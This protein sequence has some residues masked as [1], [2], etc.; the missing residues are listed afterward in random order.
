MW[1]KLKELGIWNVSHNSPT[2]LDLNAINDFFANIPVDL[3]WACDY[4]DELE[5]SPQGTPGCHFFFTPVTDADS[6]KEDYHNAPGTDG[7]HITFLKE[8]RPVILQ[9]ITNIIKNYS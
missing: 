2:T 3:S 7:V 1:N 5:S 9:I 6:Y 8:I 4:V